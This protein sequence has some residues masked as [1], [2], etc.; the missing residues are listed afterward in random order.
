MLK[1]RDEVEQSADRVSPLR[2]NTTRN[3]NI[4]LV[5]AARPD[6]RDTIGSASNALR[7][8]RERQTETLGPADRSLADEALFCTMA[9]EHAE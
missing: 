6:P 8:W 2:P 7:S 3:S 4:I 9:P 1:V 5:A